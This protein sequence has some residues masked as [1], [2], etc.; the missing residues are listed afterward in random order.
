VGSGRKDKLFVMGG[1]GTAP[2]IDLIRERRGVNAGVGFSVVR[3]YYAA[4]D[5]IN[6]LLHGQTPRGGGFPSGIGA[7]LFTRTRN[8]PPNGQRFGGTVDFTAAYRKA[9]GD[10]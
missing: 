1:E 2:I 7:Q 5:A 4:L 6:R 10:H 9:W 8:L 3:E